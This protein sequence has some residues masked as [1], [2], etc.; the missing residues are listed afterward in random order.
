MQGVRT[1][2]WETGI[3]GG[4]QPAQE[5][6]APASQFSLGVNGVDGA[7]IHT[8]AAIDAGIRVDLALFASFANGVNRAGFVTGAAVNAIFGDGMSQGIH[9]LRIDV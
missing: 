9:L 3:Q 2:S 8:G 4:I 5:G 7:G 1:K 6:P